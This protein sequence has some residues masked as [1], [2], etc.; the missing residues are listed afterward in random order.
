MKKVKTMTGTLEL[1]ENAVSNMSKG[2]KAIANFILESYD[3]AAYMTAAKLGEE[4]GVSESTVVRFTTELG[5]ECY[6]E[7]Q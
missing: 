1:I 5:F 2:H 7:F 4:V 3:K 6:P